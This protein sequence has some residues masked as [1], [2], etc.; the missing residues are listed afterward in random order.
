MVSKLCA[1][2]DRRYEEE[3]VWEGLRLFTLPAVWRSLEIPTDA[4]RKISRHLGIEQIGLD[5]AWAD[6]RPKV[7]SRL[8]APPPG[9]E[10]CRREFRSSM[11]LPALVECQPSTLRK[12]IVVA[13][14]TCGNTAQLERDMKTLRDLWHKRTKKIDSIKL[15]KQMR[16]SLN[17]AERNGGKT[18]DTR[19]TLRTL[20]ANVKAVWDNVESKHRDG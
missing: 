4:L 19:R 5:A 2:L 12:L 14:A 6:M 15:G 11:L 16:L 3:I 10:L 20:S 17:F 9:E 8:G 1:N 7:F 18:C 13:V